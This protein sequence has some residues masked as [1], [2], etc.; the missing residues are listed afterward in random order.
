MRLSQIFYP[1]GNYGE[2]GYEEWCDYPHHDVFDSIKEGLYGWGQCSG[3]IR[4]RKTKEVH[5]L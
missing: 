1:A 2:E 3:F 4:H 5:Q